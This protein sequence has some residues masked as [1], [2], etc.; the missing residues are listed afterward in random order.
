MSVD[1]SIIEYLLAVGQDIPD[2]KCDPKI[3]KQGQAV[4]ILAGPR[5]WMIEAWVQKV[6][7][8]SGLAMDWSYFGGRAVVRTLAAVDA[9]V[10][11]LS[12]YLRELELAA[13]A[14]VQRKDSGAYELQ[15]MWTNQ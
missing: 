6:S 1:N 4:L 8:L 12:N 13:K 2:S 3:W 5:S 14:A 9:A 10:K 11:A 7:E 15:Y